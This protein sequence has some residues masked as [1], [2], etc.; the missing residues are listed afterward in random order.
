MAPERIY[1]AI[2]EGGIAKGT[3]DTG[4][5]IDSESTLVSDAVTGAPMNNHLTFILSNDICETR[6]DSPSP[7]P[8]FY[9]QSGPETHA[10]IWLRSDTLS[11]SRF[12]GWQLK[13]RDW[14]IEMCP[15]WDRNGR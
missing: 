14:P 11:N 15:L 13:K 10:A 7:T 4:W 2:E 6:V 12:F 1:L 9:C 3:D 8:N 5:S